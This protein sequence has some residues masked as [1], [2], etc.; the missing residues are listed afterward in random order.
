MGGSQPRCCASPTD[1]HQVRL[2]DLREA[3]ASLE[4]EVADGRGQCQGLQA[5][6]RVPRPPGFAAAVMLHSA[7]C[8]GALASCCVQ[9][10]LPNE[11]VVFAEA[12]KDWAHPPFLTKKQLDVGDITSEV[13]GGGEVFLVDLER[14]HLFFEWGLTILHRGAGILVIADI[15]RGGAAEAANLKNSSAGADVLEVGDQI[16]LVNGVGESDLDMA[17]EL[18]QSA[19]VTLGVRRTL[20]RKTVA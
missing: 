15:Q 2:P 1:S 14:E 8:V 11:K 17:E 7:P 20:R 3:Y 5:D 18:R 16:A 10:S 12:E 9:D 4:L 6:P 13:M 19:L